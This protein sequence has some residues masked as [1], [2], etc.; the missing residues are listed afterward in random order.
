MNETTYRTFYREG[1][2]VKLSEET[3][4][5]PREWVRRKS[6]YIRYRDF[7]KKKTVYSKKKR[8]KENIR[9]I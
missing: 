3:I 7:L 4:E 8:G 1:E 9:R 5:V 2:I 6:I